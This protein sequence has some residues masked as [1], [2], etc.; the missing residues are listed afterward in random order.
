MLTS[1]EK[2]ETVDDMGEENQNKQTTNKIAA[3]QEKEGTVDMIDEGVKEDPNKR[4]SKIEISQEEKTISK[5]CITLEKLNKDNEQTIKKSRTSEISETEILKEKEKQ[6]CKKI[7]YIPLK[8]SFD[9]VLKFR[10]PNLSEINFRNEKREIAPKAMNSQ[11]W[12]NF[13]KQKEE[14]KTQKVESIGLDS[15]YVCAL[16]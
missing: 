16:P 8:V 1:Q 12:R 7:Q 9:N 11:V 14:G 10:S 2:K 6:V 15:S 4:V 3:S 13:Q 5:E